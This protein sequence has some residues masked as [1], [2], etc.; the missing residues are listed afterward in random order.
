MTADP[1]PSVTQLLV[2][3]SGGDREALDQLMAGVYGE[4]KHIAR[5]HLARERAST[6]QAT[7]LLN[8]AYLK[9][10]DQHSVSWQNRAHFFAIAARLMR[11]IVLKEARRRRAAKRGAGVVDVRIDDVEIAA[12]E[13]PVD[14]F[15][16]DEAL[17]RLAALDPRQSEIIELRFFGGLSIEDVAEILQVSTGTVKRE[18]R[19]ARAWLRKEV[20]S[21]A[22]V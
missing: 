6:L 1:G 10:V 18:W 9:L 22:D 5:Y 15:A 3:W 19:T 17:T 11:R 8:E 21:A 12:G 20:T 4:L 2:A 16:L 13:R 7:A 14:L